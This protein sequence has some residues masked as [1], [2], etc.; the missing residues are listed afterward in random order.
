MGAR[1][2]GAAPVN[3]ACTNATV[4][5]DDRVTR[6][7]DIVDTVGLTTAGVD[8]TEP[9]PECTSAPVH[10]VWYAWTAPADGGLAVIPLCLP[11]Y[12]VKL[13]VWSGTCDAPVATNGCSEEFC[14]SASPATTAV[15]ADVTYLVQVGTDA[16]PTSDLTIELCYVG[17]DQDDVDGDNVADCLDPCTD[18]DFDGFGDGPLAVRPFDVCPA[19]NCVDVYNPDQAD[20]DGDGIGDACD[21]D[22]EKDEKTLEE[23]ADEGDVELSDKNC[24]SG[25]CVRITVR[26]RGS[27]PLLVHV[28]AGDVLVSRENGEQDLGV[29][30]PIGIYVP[31]GGTATIGGLY[32]VCLQSGSHAPSRGRI[33]DV[34]DH[35]SAAPGI[36]SLAALLKLLST[37]IAPSKRVSILQDASW[38]ITDALPFGEGPAALLRAAGLDPDALPTGFPDLPNPNAGSTEPTAHRLAGLLSNSNAPI[39][40]CSGTPLQTAACLLDRVETLAAALPETVKPKLRAKIGHRIA[41]VRGKVD[42]ASRATKPRKAAKL[43][44]AALARARALAGMLGKA[45]AKGKLPS[46]EASALVD[47][48]NQV[49]AALA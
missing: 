19:D 40:G 44:R 35:L 21:M 7:F 20:K 18:S 23:A 27:R 39:G 3:D 38:A 2:A 28:R 15:L 34:T 26:N 43:Q 10:S 37:P 24:F 6:Y 49:A 11:A 12:S 9:V 14:S 33:Y 1:V 48:V 32:T 47:A 17:P 4:V 45:A 31:P 25:D 29:T 16:P 36:P 46:A 22:E 5:P 13:A 8:P 30:N 41:G 42:A